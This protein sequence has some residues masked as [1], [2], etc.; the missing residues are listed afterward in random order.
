MRECFSSVG[1]YTSNPLRAYRA[2]AVNSIDSIGTAR[3]A[4]SMSVGRSSVCV[5]LD[6]KAVLCWG[7][8]DYGAC[9]SCPCVPVRVAA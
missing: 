5:V 7:R 9:I 3:T 4:Q 1:A 2:Y 8:G 6:T